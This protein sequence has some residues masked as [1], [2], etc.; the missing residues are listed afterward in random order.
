VGAVCRIVFPKQMI[1]EHV[2]GCRNETTIVLGKSSAKSMM[3]RKT[4]FSIFALLGDC[5]AWKKMLSA[6]FVG[7]PICFLR[8]REKKSAR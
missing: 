8:E 3:T 5:A 4:W 2:L 7:F 1:D 6:L